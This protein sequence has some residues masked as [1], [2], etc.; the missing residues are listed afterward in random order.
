MSASWRVLSILTAVVNRVLVLALAAVVIFELVRQGDPETPGPLVW[1]A[2]W[3]RGEPML[4]ITA[5]TALVILNLNVV[6]VS[7]Y[8]L[9]NSPDAAFITSQTKG[10]RSRIALSAIQRALRVSAAQIVEIARVRIR[11][12]RVGKHRFRVHVRYRVRDVIYASTA[13]E[14]LRLVLKKRFS[15]LV[16]LDP[17]D[18]VE[19]DLD[20][21]GIVRGGRRPPAPKKLQAPPDVD[22]GESFRG[23]VYPVEGEVT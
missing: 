22:G 18:Q 2:D 17:K 16:I 20:L 8:S 5:A 14:R 1:A 13:A 9:S 3:I 4:A 21:A 7:L 19:F 23:P 15:E 10:G 11:V 12:S 6:Q